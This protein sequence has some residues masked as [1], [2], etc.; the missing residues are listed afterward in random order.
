VRLDGA[1]ETQREECNMSGRNLKARTARGI[2]A[3][4][5]I[6][7]APVLRWTLVGLI[8]LAPFG[9][10]S[11]A[12]SRPVLLPTSAPIPTP[13]PQVDDRAPVEQGRDQK[14]DRLRQTD[15]TSIGTTPQPLPP[16]RQNVRIVGEAY[17][18]DPSEHIELV[19]EAHARAV[20]AAEAIENAAAKSRQATSMVAALSLG[21]TH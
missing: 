7:G 2:G 21:Q 18:P 20:D 9:D 6:A 17:L 4:L 14:R 8:A 10:A 19:G 11:A 3:V 13:R 15:M 12:A 5:T 1:E 16:P